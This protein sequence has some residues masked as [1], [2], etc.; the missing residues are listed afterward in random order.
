MHASLSH[1]DTQT[2]RG[3]VCKWCTHIIVYELCTGVH[4]PRYWG[5]GRHGWVCTASS[6]RSSDSLTFSRPTRRHGG[7]SCQLSFRIGA[8]MWQRS[9]PHKRKM[10]LPMYAQYFPFQFNSR[11]L[12]LV[13]LSSVYSAYRYLHEVRA[14]HNEI[15][16]R[17]TKMEF[18]NRPQL[19]LIK[20]ACRARSPPRRMNQQTPAILLH[21]PPAPLN[22][23]MLVVELCE[24]QQRFTEKSLCWDFLEGRLARPHQPH[25][26]P[27]VFLCLVVCTSEAE[28]N[29]VSDWS[30]RH[31]SGGN[32]VQVC[33]SI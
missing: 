31:H 7:W 11:F 20:Y 30:V 5:P 15:P 3:H 25:I 19:L 24:A 16:R 29:E 1:T 28:C 9:P 23:P 4:C 32:S 17:A 13:G 6:S 33:T 26:A 18:P 21:R 12:N 22:L 10:I 2:A 27:V 14:V 8:S